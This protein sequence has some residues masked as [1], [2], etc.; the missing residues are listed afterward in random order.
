[1]PISSMTGFARV[2]GAI[3]DA[4]WAWELKSVNGRG[5]DLRL[6]VPAGLDGVE[7]A[8]R[9][10]LVKKLTRGT[11]QANL[12]LDRAQRP[13]EIKVNQTVLEALLKAA[14]AVREQAGSLVA[15]PTLDGLLAVRGVVEVVEQPDSEEM[16][17]TLTAAITQGFDSAA[18]ALIEARRIEG[19][20]VAKIIAQHVDTVETLV[21]A[22]ERIIAR[23]PASLRAR[24]EEQVRVLMDSS[25]AFD[26]DRLHQEAVLLA[27]K[28][29]VREEIDRLG[30]HIEHA[31]KLIRG[32]GA[33]GRK[34]DFLA[35]E[36]NR[37]ANTLCSKSTDREL[38]EIGL[39]LKTVIDQFREQVQNI[40]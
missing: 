16:R 35:Q 22:A 31:R 24:I 19:E 1:M 30:A 32:G 2:A 29:D 25:A 37:E 13:S 15:P 7:A 3:G 36:F 14:E 10:I 17:Q 5:F 4:T 40:E 23:L 34:L 18:T 8:A 21:A 33:I 9:E 11:I 12:T 39:S 27:T 20:N 38:T 6:R 26:A 28:A